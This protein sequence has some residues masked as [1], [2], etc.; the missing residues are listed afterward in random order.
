MSRLFLQSVEHGERPVLTANIL[1]GII[2][3]FGQ[4]LGAPVVSRLTAFE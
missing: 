3:H 1:L 2:E 4:E